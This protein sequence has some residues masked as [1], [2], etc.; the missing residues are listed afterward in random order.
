VTLNDHSATEGSSRP[1][2]AP[3]ERR[4]WFAQIVARLEPLRE[5][6][7]AKGYQ[8]ETG[9]H[10]GSLTDTSDDTHFTI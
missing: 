6:H 1:A 5:Y 10:F 3:F 8:D 4:G 2:W 9:F 7:I